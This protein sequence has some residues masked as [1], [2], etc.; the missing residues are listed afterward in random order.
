MEEQK[1]KESEEFKLTEDWPT[2]RMSASIARFVISVSTAAIGVAMILIML[3]DVFAG[4][5]AAAS[6][7]CLMLSL[8]N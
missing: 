8:R 2:P 6:V 1:A 7:I 4:L 5:L 3:P